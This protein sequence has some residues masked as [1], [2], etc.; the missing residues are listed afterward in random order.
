MSDVPRPRPPYLHRYV[1]R[2]GKAIWYVRRGAHGKRI[3]IRGECGS[4]EFEAAYQAAVT[5]DKPTAPKQPLVTKG[6]LAWLWML[7][8]QSNAWSAHKITTRKQRENIMEHVLKTAGATPLSHITKS[9]IIDGVDRRAATPFQATKFLTTMHGLFGWAHGK[10]LV[11][12]DPTIGVKVV[13]PKTAGFPVWTEA[14]I[15]MFEARWPIGTRERVML[16]VFLYTGLR[17]GDA[18][19]LGRQHIR[20][21][22]IEIDTE[23]TGMRVTIPVLP[24]LQATL[25]AGPFGELAVIATHDGQ[26]MTKESLG[27][28]F[29]DACRAAGVK[30]SAH[31]LRKAAATHA[32]NNGATVAQLEAIFGWSGGR[33]AALYTQAANRRKLAADA[34]VKLARK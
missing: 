11:S 17:R 8:H 19:R 3:R 1:T 15:E 21:G 26:P 22:V 6:T 13:K 23:K 27:N 4:P 30:K 34:V 33:M 18:A 24:V 16:D 10:N 7:Y 5:P 12:A 31:G 14:D 25:D 2:H 28:A 20:S 32:A 29:G 9:A